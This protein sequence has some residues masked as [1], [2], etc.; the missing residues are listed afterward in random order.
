MARL[1][2][3]DTRRFHALRR[4]FTTLMSMTGA[5]DHVTMKLGGWSDAKMLHYYQNS[6]DTQEQ[7]AMARVDAELGR[8]HRIAQ[9]QVS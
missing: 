6:T 9:G 5:P 1:D 4:L 8:L 2:L 3:T 7:V